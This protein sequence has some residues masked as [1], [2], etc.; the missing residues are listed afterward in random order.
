MMELTLLGTG[1][2]KVDYKRFGPANLISTKMANILVDCGS[3]I[4]QRLDQIKISTANIDALFLT[5]L[6]SDH[7]IDLYQLIISSWHSYKMNPWKIYGPKG[8]KKFVKKLMNTWKDERELRIKYE[9]RQSIEAFKIN[10]IEFGSI[11]NISIK[12]I[13]VRYFEEIINSNKT[14]DLI[15]YFYKTQKYELF[16]LIGADNLIKFHKWYKWKN[17]LKKS[18]LIV[19]DRHGYKKSSLN[20]KT[21]KNFTSKTVIFIEFNKV[22]ISSSQLRKI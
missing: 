14:T 6:H 21:Y 9:A 12:D 15:D 22:N 19:F 17:I 10:V 13:K 3:G 18:K 4:T 8:T 16:F 5:H 1:C 2:P 11:G 7:V 20:S